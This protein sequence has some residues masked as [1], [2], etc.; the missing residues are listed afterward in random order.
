MKNLLVILSGMG[1]LIG[2][3][4]FLSRG[5]SSVSIINSIGKNAT[6]GIATLQGRN[7]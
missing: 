3:Y 7:L 6:A 4:L 1:V 5:D 2:I